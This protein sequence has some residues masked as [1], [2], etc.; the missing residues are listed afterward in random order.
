MF[1]FR[2]KSLR[3]PSNM[4]VVNLALSD[5]TFS[6]VNGFPLLTISAFSRRWIF[7]KIGESVG[8][9]VVPFLFSL[10]TSSCF[11]SPV[12][13]PPPSAPHPPS[14]PCHWIKCTPYIYIKGYTLYMH[15][16]HHVTFHQHNSRIAASLA[17]SACELYAL[18]GRDLRPDVHQHN[19]H[20]CH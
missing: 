16:S 14:I 4:F 3:T 9:P 5:L 20:D 19:G 8:E 18:V 6:A 10:T 1:A 15:T 17:I 11:S 13:C 2:T 12:L 7:G